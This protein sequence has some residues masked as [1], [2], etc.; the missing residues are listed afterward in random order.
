MASPASE[1]HARRLV[2]LDQRHDELLGKLDELN[3][4]IV[5]TLATISGTEEATSAPAVRSC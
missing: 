2:R 1:E 4:R 5:C 3:E